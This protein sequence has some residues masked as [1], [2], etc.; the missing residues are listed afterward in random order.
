M[1]GCADTNMS[2]TRKNMDTL[3]HAACKAKAKKQQ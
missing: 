1:I 2:W 3:R